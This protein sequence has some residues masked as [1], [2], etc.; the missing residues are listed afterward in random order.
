MNA[1]SEL[2]VTMPNLVPF[3]ACVPIT[4]QIH[5]KSVT[6]VFDGLLAR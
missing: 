6:L 5:Q 1:V 4:L 3:R 2:V